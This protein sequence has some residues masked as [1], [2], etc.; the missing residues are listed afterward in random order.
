M[1]NVF[2]KLDDAAKNGRGIELT[3]SEVWL[4]MELTGEEIATQGSV[5]EH[6]REVFEDYEREKSRDN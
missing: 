4:L 2:D 6:W 5:Y 1:E 3:S